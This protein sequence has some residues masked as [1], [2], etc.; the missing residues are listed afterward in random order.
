M[1]KKVGEKS[2]SEI[3]TKLFAQVKA[4]KKPACPK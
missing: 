2:P 1:S 3:F 4:K